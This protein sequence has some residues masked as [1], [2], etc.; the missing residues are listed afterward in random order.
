M[1]DAIL[2]PV[3]I[4]DAERA[5]GKAM[6]ASNKYLRWYEALIYMARR[7]SLD[8]Y[9]EKHHTIPKSLGGHK[10]EIVKLTYREHF[11]AHWLLTKFTSGMD[12][13]RMYHALG[14]MCAGVGSRSMAAWQ[15]AVSRKAYVLARTGRKHSPEAIARMKEAQGAR[16][17]VRTEETKAKMSAALSGRIFSEEHRQKLRV[18]ALGKI[19]PPEQRAKLRAA[20]LGRKPSAES[21][22][23]NRLAQLGKI[24][25]AETRAKISAAKRGHTTSEY[26][27]EMVRLSNRA[28]IYTDETREKMSA[29]QK[30]RRHSEETKEKIRVGNLNKKLSPET[31]ARISAAQ[32]GRKHSEETKAKM[33]A[34]HLAHNRLRGASST[35]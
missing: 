11:L 34:S 4:R 27:K 14:M 1:A 19:I 6:F 28:R 33:R 18:A 20:N 29:A 24:I 31:R 26:T 23:K 9:V 21:L 32:I 13:R 35:R 22:E 5:D 7:R 30:G 10:S 3:N 8:A 17:R 25:T 2:S 15:Y 12:Q 16:N